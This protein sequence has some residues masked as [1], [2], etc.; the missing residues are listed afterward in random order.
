MDFGVSAR[1]ETIRA[2][3]TQKMDKDV[4]HKILKVENCTF[5]AD[6]QLLGYCHVTLQEHARLTD[7][8]ISL[9]ISCSAYVCQ[10][11]CNII[12]SISMK[13]RRS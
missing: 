12:T 7:K 2:V 6:Q 9:F 10:L 8:F 3:W 4:T 11:Q 1:C 13:E 5:F